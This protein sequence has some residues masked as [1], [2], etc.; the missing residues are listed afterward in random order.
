MTA[1]KPTEHSVTCADCGAAMRLRESRY[2]WFY[3]CEK[4]PSCEGSHGAHPDGRPMGT[5]ANAET[6]RARRRAHEVFDTLWKGGAM[7]RGDAYEWLAQQ[8]GR[9][10]HIADMDVADCDRVVALVKGRK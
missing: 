4:F 9:P 3:S 7:R 1:E 5:P 6:K 2:G 10:A 8:F